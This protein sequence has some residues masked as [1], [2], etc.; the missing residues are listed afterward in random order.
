MIRERG[1]A[2]GFLLAAAVLVRLLS[3]P[4]LLCAQESPKAYQTQYATIHY[5][6]TQDLYTFTRNTGSG[7]SFL[8]ESPEKNPLLLKTQVDKIVEK[9]C[10]LLDMHPPTLHFNITLY[11]TQR[12]VAA[13]YRAKGMMGSAPISFYSHNDRNITV[14]IDSIDDHILA[15]EMAHAVICVYFVVPPPGPMQEI[16]AQYMDKHFKD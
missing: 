10:M 9:I 6:D 3:S 4:A 5:K 7:M 16:L 8:R 1:I 2:A 14:A 12:E 15:H 13:I 11:K